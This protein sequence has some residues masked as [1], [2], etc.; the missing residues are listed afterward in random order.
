MTRP[1]VYPYFSK[2]KYVVSLDPRIIAAASTKGGVLIVTPVGF[3]KVIKVAYKDGV[4]VSKIVIDEA[5]EV[6]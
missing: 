5:L 1:T 4:Q 2:N 3:F 6:K